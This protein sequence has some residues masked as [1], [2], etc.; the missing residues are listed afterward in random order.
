MLRLASARAISA[1][2]Y[3]HPPLVL[4]FQGAIHVLALQQCEDI[5]L[6][7][8]FCGPLAGQIWF[9]ILLSS[10]SS[11]VAVSATWLTQYG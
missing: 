8:L 9:G 5:D 4:I 6:I 11:H 3:H 1:F 7:L 10:N 2:S